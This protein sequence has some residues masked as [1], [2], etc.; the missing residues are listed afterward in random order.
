MKII[1]EESYI[2][3][4]KILKNDGVIAIATDTVFGVCARTMSKKAFEKL[5]K[6]KNRPKEKAFPIMCKDISDMKLVG[7]IDNKTETIIENFMPGPL[8]IIVKKKDN[9]PIYIGEGKETIAIRM[10]TSDVL[11]KII[12]ELGEPIF[13]TSANRS[14]EEEY[15]SIKEIIEKLPLVDGVVESEP[16][17]NKASTI[18]DTINMKILREGPI[19]LEEINKAL[20]G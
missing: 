2:E 7:V 14:G 9:L 18:L 19:T 16:N 12:G 13:M 15:K 4:V 3:A 10:A 8:T 17:Y 5:I 6:V 11:D 1:K 20:G